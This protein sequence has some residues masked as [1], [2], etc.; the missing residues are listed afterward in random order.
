[1]LSPFQ[2]MMVQYWMCSSQTFHTLHLMDLIESCSKRAFYDNLVNLIL[3]VL[4]GV[5]HC[6]FVVYIIVFHSTQCMHCHA[7]MQAIG[8]GLVRISLI[9]RLPNLCILFSMKNIEKLR[10]GPVRSKYS[11]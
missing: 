10:V 6:R 9:P 1:M 2:L 8:L 3:W 11:L 4:Y 7:T 5:A